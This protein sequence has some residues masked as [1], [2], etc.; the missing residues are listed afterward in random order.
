MHDETRMTPHGKVLQNRQ[1]R[2]GIALG[3]ACALLIGL[4][5]LA[6]GVAMI[7]VGLGGFK[8]YGDAPPP[9]VCFGLGGAFALAGLFLCSQGVMG[10]RR[11]YRRRRFARQQRGQ[12][13]SADHPW[14]VTG[15]TDHAGRKL[16]WPFGISG[17]LFVFLMPFNYFFFSGASSKAPWFVKTFI[18]LFDGAFVVMLGYA[19]YCL[20]R[21]LKYGS[22]S[23][24]FPRFPFF[25]GERLEAQF[26]PP[27]EVR[28]CRSM[29]ITLRCI[30]ER[31]E[32]DSDNS[33]V[34]RCYEIYADTLLVEGD[35]A[36]AT[37]PA[38]PIAFDLPED[39]PSTAL[40]E[41]PPVYWEIEIKANV[42]GIDYRT[43]LLVP[44]YAKPDVKEP[45][46]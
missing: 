3:S 13:W 42:P 11:K 31:F 5:F 6:A 46:P 27:G 44:V 24:R 32:T 1:G 12:P 23:L 22:S 26:V 7:L 43:N 9:V 21:Y 19:L 37:Y 14:D 29:N 39:A 17:F 34:V 10:L 2:S 28:D 15:T 45:T 36:A 18:G 4:P 41:R 8:P 33:N 40:A 30:K 16:L 20:A 35:A 25:L 38:I